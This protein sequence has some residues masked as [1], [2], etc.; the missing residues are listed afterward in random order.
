MVVPQGAYTT[1]LEGQGNFATLLACLPKLCGVSNALVT[2][3]ALGCSTSAETTF[4]PVSFL[5]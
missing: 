5:A 1:S 2:C 3:L 4:F